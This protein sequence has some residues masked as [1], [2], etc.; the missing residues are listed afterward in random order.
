MEEAAAEL[1]DAV[2][3]RAVPLAVQLDGSRLPSGQV[4][5]S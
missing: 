4:R 3:G 5:P 1:V 2:A